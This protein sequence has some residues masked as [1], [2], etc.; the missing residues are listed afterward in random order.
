MEF[1]SFVAFSNDDNKTTY[2][3]LCGDSTTT[4][5]QEEI[6]L[7]G[8][9]KDVKGHNDDTEARERTKRNFL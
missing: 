3:S 2:G 4:F 8:V 5:T 1:S 9:Y 6:L 7:N